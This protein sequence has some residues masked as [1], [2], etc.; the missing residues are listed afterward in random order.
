MTG[1][2]PVVVILF[3]GTI[4]VLGRTDDRQTPLHTKPCPL[5]RIWYEYVQVIIF[6]GDLLLYPV[7]QNLTVVLAFFGISC[8]LHCTYYVLME[9]PSTYRLI[10]RLKATYYLLGACLTGRNLSCILIGPTSLQ[11]RIEIQWPGVKVRLRLGFRVPWYC[12]RYSDRHW[13]G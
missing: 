1:A 6:C 2:E 10:P 8:L 5:Y 9:V 7:R 4:N 11:I 12:I 13:L 3:T